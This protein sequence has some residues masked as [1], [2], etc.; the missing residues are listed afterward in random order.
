[1]TNPDV[2]LFCMIY[3]GCG[4]TPAAIHC[5]N[6]KTTPEETNRQHLSSLSLKVSEELS[7][8][9][10][11]KEINNFNY[12]IQYISAIHRSTQIMQYRLHRVN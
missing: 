1:M 8:Q 4:K 3:S 6:E 11:S 10:L 7:W 9:T 2:T 12:F 5:K